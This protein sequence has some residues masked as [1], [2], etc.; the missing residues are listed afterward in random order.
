MIE[1]VRITLENEMDLVLAHKKAVSL[2][3]NLQLTLTTQTVFAAA[4]SEIA[5]EV[6]ERTNTGVIIL[7]LFKETSTYSLQAKIECGDKDCCNSK[8]T[9]FLY[10]Q[11]LVPSYTESIVE[12]K[13]I[14]ELKIKIPTSIKIT[15]ASIAKLIN[16]FENILPFTP[17]E[18]VKRKMSSMDQL[19]KQ[20]EE[21]LRHSKYL[22]EKKN[23]FISMASH[24]LKTPVTIIKAYAQLAKSSGKENCS[25]LVQNFISKIEDQAGKLNS[26]IKQLLDVSKLERDK[27]DYKMELLSVNTFVEEVV[28]LIRHAVPK[29]KVKLVLGEDALVSL[30]TFRMEQVFSNI[31]GNAAKYSPDSDQITVKTTLSK[32]KGITISIKDEGLGMSKENIQKVFEK[33]HRNDEV[34]LSY[35]G[36]GLGLY[37]SSKIINEHGGEIWVESEI[38]RG[39]TFH[40]SIPVAES[41]VAV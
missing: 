31:L 35:A 4:I 10:A 26:L 21:E 25:A 24:E 28:T 29:H 37:I 19:T 23:D 40:F 13:R 1:I 20:Q 18:A 36:L 3:E 16:H 8:E 15:P 12:H 38:D 39:S 5:R 17:Y 30:D 32:E 34:V 7:G 22:D 2:G 33:F 6:I 14:I 41:R 27:L 9:G 11:K